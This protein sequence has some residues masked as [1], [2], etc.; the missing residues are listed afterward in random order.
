MYPRVMFT[1]WWG[2]GYYVDWR[3]RLVK[4]DKFKDSL[5]FAEHSLPAFPEHPVEK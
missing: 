3:Q 1:D 5:V 2:N 4:Y